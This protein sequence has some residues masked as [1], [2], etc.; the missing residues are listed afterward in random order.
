MAKNGLPNEASVVH[1]SLSG[2][3]N[4]ASVVLNESSGYHSEQSGDRNGTFVYHN[5]PSGCLNRAF[6]SHKGQ[7]GDRN[8]PALLFALLNSFSYYNF[9]K[10]GIVLQGKD[11]IF[12][13]NYF[14]LVNVKNRLCLDY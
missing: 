6:G 1:N 8:E 5:E 10:C 9:R 7:S 13:T 12:F 2:D 11:A 3:P 4:R 14:V